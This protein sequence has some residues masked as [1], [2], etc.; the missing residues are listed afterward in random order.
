MGIYRSSDNNEGTKERQKL[1]M[2]KFISNPFGQDSAI[3]KLAIPMKFNKFVSPICL[4]SCKEESY[5]NVEAVVSGWGETCH[6]GTAC[7]GPDV[8][9]KV[10]MN[11][12]QKSAKSEGNTYFIPR[13]KETV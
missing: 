10:T 12:T 1:P 6:N 5:A 8:L 7:P 11:K 2:A 13:I 9:Q 3:V 4:P